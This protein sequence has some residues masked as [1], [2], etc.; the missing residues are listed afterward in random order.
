MVADLLFFSIYVYYP[1][2][3]YFTVK[4]YWIW[5]VNE[6]SKTDFQ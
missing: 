4:F 5:H 2:K 6:G 3:S 1:Y